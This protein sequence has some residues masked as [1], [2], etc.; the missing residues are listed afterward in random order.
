MKKRE[1]AVE[2]ADTAIPRRVL[3]EAIHDVLRGRPLRAAAFLT[4]QFDPGF[5]EQE[6]LPVFFDVSLSHV[7][8]IRLLGLAEEMRKVESV[9]VYYDRAALIAGAQSSLLDIQRIAVSQPTG[10]FHPK[11][12]LALVEDALVVAATS[13]NLTRSGWWENVEV[14]HIEEVTQ[15]KPS[16]FR[17][18]LLA[19]TKRVRRSA[20]HATA[21]DALDA[22]DGFLRKIPQD[23]QRMRGGIVLPRLFFG[24][25]DPIEFLRDLA[26]KRLYGCNLE[27][28]SP[29]FD[30]QES[31]GPIER[32]REAFRPRAMRIFLPRKPEG[33]ALCSS[34][35]YDRVR[36][37][38][39]W[40]HLPAA[41]MRLT[42]GLERSLHAKVYRFFDRESC[43]EALFIGSANLTNAALNRGGNVESGFFLETAPNRK[44]DWWIVA[45]DERPIAFAM[46]SEADA[47][48]QGR[49]WRLSV[50]YRWSDG[51]A[52]CFWDETRPSPPLML[53]SHGGGLAELQPLPPRE[54]VALSVDVAGRIAT[55]LQSGSFLTVRIANEPDAQILVEEEQMTHK[56]SLMARVTAADIL[57]YW[58][59]LTPEQKKEFLEEHA[60]A[61][62]DPE[63]AMWLGEKRPVSDSDT[64]FSTFAAVYLSFGNLQRAVRTAIA[65]GRQREAVERLF[66][67]KFD[68]LRRLIERVAEEEDSD[69]VRRYVVLLCA[70]QLLDGLEREEPKLVAENRRDVIDLRGQLETASE[71]RKTIG[72]GTETERDQFFKWFDRWFL[73]SAQPLPER[74]Q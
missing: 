7:T 43:Y 9:A 52:S 37:V 5:F 38:A 24:D 73:R 49:G 12:V 56:P 30:D 26:G 45:E 33:D 47:L 39:S 22:I 74:A 15:E 28:L 55:A 54:W 62:D 53:L 21:H 60:D 17:D 18:D 11:I 71:I 36:Q 70:R 14:A 46:R 69:A 64:F 20:R 72:F 4:F 25:D 58:S 57:R 23:E 41:V 66:G 34:M 63:L 3:S 51:T 48:A 59:L 1:P 31:A 44:P 40:G 19:L 6:I 27:I 61:F 10:Y 29:F 16:S 68:S 50:R 67:R 13:A 8:E 2:T 35:Y 32:L 65:A 42:K